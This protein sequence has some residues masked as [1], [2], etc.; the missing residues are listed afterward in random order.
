MLRLRAA[1]AGTTLTKTGTGGTLSL[2]PTSGANTFSGLI[3][4][5]TGTLNTTTAGVNGNAASLTSGISIAA[6]GILQANAASGF[7]LNAN[8]PVIVA[9][10]AVIDT[11]G[12]N[13]TINGVVSGTTLIKSGSGTLT[14]TNGANSFTGLT[15]Q[16]GTLAVPS[17]ANVST[18]QP[19]GRMA[20]V[21]LGGSNSTGTIG[22]TGTS[23]ATTQAFSIA[24]TGTGAF[25]IDSGTLTLTGV[26]SS[27]TAGSGNLQK[28]G[29]GALSLGVANT[30]SGG[31]F[32]INNGTVVATVA[33]ARRPGRNDARLRIVRKCSL[34]TN[35]RGDNVGRA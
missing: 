28:D 26:I 33:G 22:F 12:A 23:G 21:T 25:S 34:R 2:A 8:V 27:A 11:N 7:S 19:W 10:G 20:T 3:T 15:V 4:I 9:T 16:N 14:L 32:K 1:L 18:F 35:R 6:A 29:A 13:A 24:N 30:Y 31:T 5:T 17:V